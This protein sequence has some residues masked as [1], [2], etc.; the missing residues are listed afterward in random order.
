M[1]KK[2]IFLLLVILS[3][4]ISV[5]TQEL[6]TDIYVDTAKAATFD[7]RLGADD[8]A[9][10]AIL[11]GGNM[12]GNLELCD[13]NHPRGGLARRIGYLETFRKKFKDTPILNVD[14]G[15]FWY[16]SEA[17]T[18]HVLLQNNFVSQAYSLW[19]F[20]VINLGRYDLFY[21]S[22]LLAREGLAERAA[23][24]PMIKNL[25]SAN[26]VFG[27]NATPPAPYVIK[28]VQ[29]P[30]IQGGKKS[31]KIAFLGLAEPIK[32]GAGLVDAGVK[33]LYATARQYVPKLRKECDLLVI[34]AH[35][36][37]ATAVRLANENPEADIV[38]AGDSGGLYKPRQIGKTVVVS[39]APGNTQQGDLRIYLS[40]D[41]KIS[42]KF[43]ATDL[44]ALVPIDAAAQ[45]FTEE[46]R[47]EL[48]KVKDE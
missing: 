28:E 25:I 32:P 44:D 46:T 39:A 31:L 26:G 29:G 4:S 18:P 14:A 2:S 45:A 5:L 41:G 34:L 12:R 30:R 1:F 43:R 3:L 48:S 38:I 35:G 22:R 36:E 47:V 27:E 40:A 9:A 23:K 17:A 33:D 10:L 20:D 19:E 21:A 13:C 7:Q 24:L 6:A 42:Y 8:G 15:H 11:F 37:L 16:N